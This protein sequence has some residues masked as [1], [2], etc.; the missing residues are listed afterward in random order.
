LKR[1]S[2]GSDGF[3][4]WSTDCGMRLEDLLDEIHKL[5]IPIE[6]VEIGT[7]GGPLFISVDVRP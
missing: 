4:V 2:D 1:E 6:E 5:G 7:D 3:L